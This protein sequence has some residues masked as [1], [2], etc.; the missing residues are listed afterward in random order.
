MKT[1]VS[2]WGHLPDC[3]IIVTADGAKEPN[4][5]YEEYLDAIEGMAKVGWPLE[6]RRFDR[7]VHQ[8]GMMAEILPTVET[9]LL[10]YLEH[11]WWLLPPVEWDMM[12]RVILEGEANYIKLYQGDRIHP[13]HEHMMFRRRILHGVGLIDTVQYSA[14]P[15]LAST[16]WYRSLTHLF[17]GKTDYIENLLHGPVANA[18]WGVFKCCIYNP[19]EAGMRRTQH[20]D[21]ARSPK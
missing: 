1:L 2:V 3:P 11:D 16:D 5:A 19:V 8:S 13:L 4:T 18:P 7:H 10:L 6:V 17:T 12:A 9:K 20:L 15:H 21:G 14:N